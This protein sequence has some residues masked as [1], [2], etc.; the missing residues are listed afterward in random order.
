MGLTFSNPKKIKNGQTIMR[1]SDFPTDKIGKNDCWN[2]WKMHKDKLK[3]DGFSITKD[4]NTDE[5]KICHYANKTDNFDEK[6]KKWSKFLIKVKDI[7]SESGSESES[8]SYSENLSDSENKKENLQEYDYKKNE[9]KDLK[10]LA[11]ILKNLN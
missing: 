1:I 6:Y 3:E 7:S 8:E 5:W 9:E 10:E 11:E 2:L 4:K